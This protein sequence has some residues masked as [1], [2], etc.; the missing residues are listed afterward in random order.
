MKFLINFTHYLC[1]GKIETGYTKNE[2]GCDMKSYI[3][4]RLLISVFTIFAITLILFILLH[5]MPGTPFNDEKLTYDQKEIFFR[6]YG[7]DKPI[8]TQFFIYIKNI[9]HGDFGTSYS[10]SKNT[11]IS[12][13]LKT[14]LPTSFAIGLQAVVI[15]TLIGVA[16]GILVALNKKSVWNTVATIIAVL[17]VSIPSYVFALFFSY[18][19]GYKAKIFPLFYQTNNM[20]MSTVLP[21]IS[22]SIYVA[23]FMIRFTRNTMLEILDSEYILFAKSKGLPKRKIIMNHTLRN[24]LIPIVTVIGPLLVWL[25]SG[26]VIIENI[27][28][29][30]GIGKLLVTAIQSNDYN[31][32]IAICLIYSVMYIL[33]MIIIDLLYIVIDPRIRI[34]KVVEN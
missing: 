22:L 12:I 8:Y 29:I 23:A 2:R 15:G 21:V 16:I 7:L 30:P 34:V 26:S 3:R 1:K 5:I 9:L 28:A 18:M 10:V 11:S 6:K 24:A 14:C 19:F 17:G 32:I 13:L 25:M 33:A 4:K 27:F 20:F 31:V